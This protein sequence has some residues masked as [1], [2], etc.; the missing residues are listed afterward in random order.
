[1]NNTSPGFSTHFTRRAATNR[2]NL[3]RSGAVISTGDI[4]MEVL[5]N[6]ESREKAWVEGLKVKIASGI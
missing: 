2:G 1:M 4:T 6:R 3:V 5:S